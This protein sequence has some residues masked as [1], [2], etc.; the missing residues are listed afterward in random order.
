[1]MVPLCIPSIEIYYVHL[2]IHSWMKVFSMKWW[3]IPFD[4]L[5]TS[6]WKPED[7]VIMEILMI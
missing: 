5:S 6:T 1:M 7:Y 4:K 3:K 2:I